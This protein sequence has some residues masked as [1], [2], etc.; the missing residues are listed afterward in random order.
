MPS[1]ESPNLPIRKW[2]NQHKEQQMIYAQ[3]IYQR[4]ALALVA[5]CIATFA[6]WQPAAAGCRIPLLHWYNGASGTT[7]VGYIGGNDRFI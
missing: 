5:I 4:L 2:F 6:G 3:S 7:A 1:P